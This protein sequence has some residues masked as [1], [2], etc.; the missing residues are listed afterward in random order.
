LRSKGAS[1]ATNVAEA[2]DAY[3]FFIR[4]HRETLGRCFHNVVVYELKDA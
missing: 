4:D 3:E 2:N 1:D